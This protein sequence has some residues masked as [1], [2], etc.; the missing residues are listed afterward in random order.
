MGIDALDQIL[1][2]D[3]H[4]EA[5]K[6]EQQHALETYKQAE[7]K[8]IADAEAKAKAEIEATE[9]KAKAQAEDELKQKKQTIKQQ[10]DARH[11]AQKQYFADHFSEFVQT[12]QEEVLKQYGSD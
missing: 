12:V 6:Q 11:T 4:I 8:K 1:T 5:V 10:F 2:L 9:A 7:K 3:D